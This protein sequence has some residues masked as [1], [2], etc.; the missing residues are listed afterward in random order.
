M[1]PL[2]YKRPFLFCHMLVSLDGKIMGKYMETQKCEESARIF[3]EIAFGGRGGYNLQGWLSGR[4]TTDDNFTLYEQPDL[5]ENAAPVPEGDYVPTT[6]APL[7]YISIDPHGRLGWKEN[8]L[9][10][11]GRTARVLEVLT[12]DASNA[13]R[14][15]L[16][17]LEIP[18]I[19]CGS[20]NPD[21]AEDD[22]LD[23]VL[24]MH[25]LSDT[26]HFTSLMLGGGGVLN[27]SFIEAGVCDEIS[28][29]VA[30]AADGST[31]TPSVFEA[32]GTHSDTPVEFTAKAAEVLEGG[33][34]WLRYTCDN[35]K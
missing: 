27:W 10:Y 23:P 4:I 32:R 33:T 15:F 30:P 24:T 20:K 11:A 28:L 12:E 3:D 5:D 14:T 18:Y 2:K 1:G 25:K 31:E 9:E 26:F 8:Y 29:V 6:E 17:R 21:A 7:W 35:A 34:V 13:Y 16:R 22:E 19:I